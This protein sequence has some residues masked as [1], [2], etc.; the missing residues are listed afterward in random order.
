MLFFQAWDAASTTLAVAAGAVFNAGVTWQVVKSIKE[1]AATKA[2][3]L[4]T[5][6]DLLSELGEKYVETKLCN[7]KHANLRRAAGADANVT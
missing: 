7:E 4:Q 5:K 6:A 3:L 1:N 2:D